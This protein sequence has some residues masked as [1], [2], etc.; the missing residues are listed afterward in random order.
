MVIYPSLSR[1]KRGA[2]PADIAATLQSEIISG[3]LSGG[4]VL[5]QDHLAA[6]FKVSRMPIREALSLLAA[7]GL[8]DLTANRSARVAVLSRSDLVDIFDMRLVAETLAIRLAMPQITNAQIDLAAGIQRQIETADVA[9][10]GVLNT[11]FHDALYTLC[12]RPRLLAHITQLGLASDRYLRAA[13]S[14]FDHAD[15]SNHEH[16]TLLKAC[17]ARDEAA[18][19]ACL[20]EH[21]S[22]ARDVLAGR[23][24]GD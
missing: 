10:F 1:S 6:R 17:Y 11:R 22:D 14:V 3:V 2:Q 16:Q 19:I 18:A 8:V 12:G 7:R 5:Q 4:Q 23:I 20:A 21:I 13:H 24:E 15:K 9:Q